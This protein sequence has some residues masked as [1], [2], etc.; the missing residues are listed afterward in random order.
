[1]TKHEFSMLVTSIVGIAA[2]LGP[3]HL[4]KT[5]MG[6]GNGD[7]G[8]LPAYEDHETHRID[9][10]KTWG[11]LDLKD[12]SEIENYLLEC[13]RLWMPIST[14]H[15][16][17]TEPFTTN[18]RGKEY[19]FPAGTLMLIPMIMGMLSEKFW[20][21]DTY[22]F[23]HK[24][25]KLC[26][27]SMV[28]HSV[29]DRSH[30]RI[31]P[32]K[33]LALTMLTDALIVCGKV[34]RS[35][36]VRKD[37]LK[38]MDRYTRLLVEKIV[39]PLADAEAITDHQ[40]SQPS[41][42]GSQRTN[43]FPLGEVKFKNHKKDQSFGKNPA[44]SWL[45]LF[46]IRR[47]LIF[48]VE[49]VYKGIKDEDVPGLLYYTKL[50]YVVPKPNVPF[51]E[52]QSDAGLTRQAF[53]GLGAHRVTSVDP[54]KPGVPEQAVFM[55]DLSSMTKF[56]VRPGFAKYGGNAYF[57]ADQKPVAIRDTS[58]MLVKPVDGFKW[59]MAK[60]MWRTSLVTLVTVVDHLYHT[61]FFVAA[62]TL[63]A[64]VE[65]LPTEHPLR[66][67][68]HP[69]LMRTALINNIAGGSLLVDNSFVEHMTAFTEDALHK[70]ATA[71]YQKGPEW[72]ALPKHVASK[73]A[74]IHELIKAGQLPFY[75]DGLEL[76]HIYR[77]FY[78]K[79]IDTNESAVQSDKDL[80]KFWSLLVKYTQAKDL[81]TDLTRD[82][83]LNALAN[84]TFYVTAG[85][86]QVGSVSDSM[87]TPLHG[88]FRLAP[89]TLRVDKQSF[90]IGMALLALTSL[91]TPPL[92]SAFADYWQNASEKRHWRSMQT[93]LQALSKRV[94][95]RNATRLFTVQNANPRILEC[96]VSI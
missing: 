33:S 54:S 63:R 43:T 8:F 11:E 41:G 96:S 36:P 34:R 18:I 20:G 23:N 88:G 67:A 2:L 82:G 91:R 22:E 74:A 68:M 58:G 89:D 29:G 6:N 60:A 69:F 72:K 66:R 3:Y 49:D 61:H 40:L 15:H 4:A 81:S 39:P 14:S 46:F 86:E 17:A 92:L 48:P 13:G 50:G 59:E 71:N 45:G 62:Q 10:R 21:A 38:G 47:D 65:G 83:L 44:G 1:M 70:V 87:E 37:Y 93:E 51:L 12:R 35:I 26:P 77:S 42:R 64:C 55:V 31:C 27:Y 5:A 32:G 24:R 73:G 56:D 75:H 79:I 57:S 78:D 19:T 85:H 28:F 53:Y 30:G 90:I 84:F 52:P 7:G 16:V 80:T 95:A 9:V 94:D 76:W 25:E